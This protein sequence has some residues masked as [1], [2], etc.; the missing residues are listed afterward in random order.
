MG[1]QVDHLT[2]T[3]PRDL[4]RKAM[5]VPG[6]AK[7]SPVSLLRT[8]LSEYVLRRQ[9][10]SR[11]LRRAREARKAYREGRT[12]VLKSLSDLG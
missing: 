11:L 8:A 4:I 1:R 6:G 2:I 3:L 12:K 5:D 7:R 9:D 10:E